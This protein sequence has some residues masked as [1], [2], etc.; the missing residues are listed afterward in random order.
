[1][2]KKRKREKYLLATDPSHRAF[3][4]KSFCSISTAEVAGITCNQM[5]LKIYTR[6]TKRHEGRLVGC[7]SIG[8]KNHHKKNWQD[9]SPS[10]KQMK[11]ELRSVA[12]W[13]E[14]MSRHYGHMGKS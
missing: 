13:S 7:Q 3:I 8:E 4:A 14:K 11:R 9:T 2:R 10:G 1:M 5:M 12:A 6:S